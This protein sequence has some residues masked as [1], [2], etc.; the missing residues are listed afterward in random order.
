M[1]SSHQVFQE[2]SLFH[3]HILAAKN[4]VKVLPV[5]LEHKIF[6]KHCCLAE[7]YKKLRFNTYYIQHILHSTYTTFNT[8]YIQHILHS[9]YT[10]FKIIIFFC[11]VWRWRSSVCPQSAVWSQGTSDTRKVTC[12]RYP[13]CCVYVSNFTMEF[14]AVPGRPTEEGD[15]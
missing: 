11:K 2:N 1:T 5:M 15:T 14:L 9:T 4:R 6:F 12:W 7:P 8:Y 13:S 10:K 3:Q